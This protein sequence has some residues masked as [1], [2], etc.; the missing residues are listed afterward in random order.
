MES[1][2]NEL[3]IFSW[4]Q[5]AALN[6]ADIAEVEAAINSFPGRI[7]RDQWVSQARELVARFPD[8]SDR[9]S[10]ETFLNRSD[11]DTPYR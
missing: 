4:E 2:L 8:R 6:P 3:D 9:P 5:L 10:S 7:E 11:D 1:V